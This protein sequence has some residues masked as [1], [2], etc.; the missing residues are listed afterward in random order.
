MLMDEIKNRIDTDVKA[1]I[2]KYPEYNFE[3]IATVK[4]PLARGADWNDIYMINL[5]LN[6]KKSGTKVNFGFGV[7][8]ASLNQEG[9]D[10]GHEIVEQVKENIKR[11][12]ESKSGDDLPAYRKGYPRNGRKPKW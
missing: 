11:D 5:N 8:V 10:L 2:I 3:L 1:M 6:H 7:S 4:M 12:Q 9:F